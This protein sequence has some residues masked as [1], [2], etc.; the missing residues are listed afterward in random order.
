MMIL[1]RDAAVQPHAVIGIAALSSAAVQISVRDKWIGWNSDDLLDAM[2]SDPSDEAARWLQRTVVA[3]LAELYVDDLL[4]DKIIT[5][6]E[7]RTPTHETISALE[8]EATQ[9]REEHQRFGARAHDHRLAGG[10]MAP[11]HWRV[12]AESPLFR[13]K[14]AE[15]LATLL[16]AQAALATNGKKL[17][18]RALAKLLA[19]SDGRRAVRSIIKRARAERVG[20][21]MADITVC[22]AVAPY[23]A[24]LGG[25]LVS[26]LLTSPEVVASYRERYRTSHSVIASSMAARPIVRASDL[27]LLCTT[28]L[29]GAGSSQYNR[30]RMP[31]GD[32]G[33]GGDDVIEY[34]ELGQTAGYGTLQFGNETIDAI[35]TFLA[36]G[37]GGQRVKS[38][39]G[40]GVSPR[41]RKVR[42]GLDAL[43][44]PSDDLLNHGSPRVVYGVALARN[45]REYLL[46]RASR[47]DYILANEEPRA[48]TR[49]IARWWTSRW[50]GG[51]VERADVLEAVRS[52]RLIHPIRHGARVVLPREETEQLSLLGE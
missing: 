36:Q 22:G 9:R 1:V 41:M 35:E 11:D 4:A 40:E 44:F 25:K 12:R 30:L 50:L 2:T 48:A 3:S 51:R 52:H 46:G 28:S 23:N 39:F 49:S 21:A 19:T 14:R 20:T 34:K 32:V 24:L 13:S 37:A 38:I 33:G 15:L 17:T 7:L 43:E 31:C 6:K 26:M 18:G 5:R 29:Y 27:V 47:P 45:F 8:I 10:D 16:R 42:D